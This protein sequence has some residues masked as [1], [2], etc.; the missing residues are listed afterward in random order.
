MSGRCFSITM[1]PLYLLGL[2]WWIAEHA[3]ASSKFKRK[4]AAFFQAAFAPLPHHELRSAP[5]L[6]TPGVGETG[7]RELS[8]PFYGSLIHN[9][10]LVAG[11]QQPTWR[12][13]DTVTFVCEKGYLLLDP[14]ERALGSEWS[15][16]CEAREMGS[17]SGS[18][19]NSTSNSSE[20]YWTWN[21]E[22]EQLRCSSESV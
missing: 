16:T 15:V 14:S 21:R 11:E 17:G 19:R 12:E 4:K 18:G 22:P 7:C 2:L 3:Y 5:L 6:P 1:T 8:P 13:N 9:G 10:S 20:V